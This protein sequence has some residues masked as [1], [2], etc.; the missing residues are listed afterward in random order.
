MDA[1]TPTVITPLATPQ[2]ID[3]PGIAM[4]VLPSK[5]STVFAIASVPVDMCVD[6]ITGH[7]DALSSFMRKGSI[8]AG[9]NVSISESDDG[10][11]TI[12]AIG[13]GGGSVDTATD[14]EFEEYMGY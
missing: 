5:E 11:L 3:L 9:S 10:T 6:Y 2:E 14:E 7:G 4:P 12:S 8:E 1:N 13:G